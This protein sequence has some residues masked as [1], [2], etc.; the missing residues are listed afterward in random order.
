[1]IRTIEKQLYSDTIAAISTPVGEGAVGIVRLSGDQAFEILERMFKP[2]KNKHLP[3]RMLV[4]GHIVRD[5]HILDEVLAVR[6]KAPKTYTCEDVVEIQCHGGRIAIQEVLAFALSL[7]AR[8]AERGEFTK[9]AFLNGRI[10]LSQAESVMDL[11]GA[12]TKRGYDLAVN[13]LEGAL[14]R[15]IAELRGR[16]IEV[17]ADI[18]V[19]IDYPEEDIEAL[20]YDMLSQKLLEVM[21]HIQVLLQGA[22]KGKIIRDGV[23]TA[24]I[25]KPNVGKSSLMNALLGTSKAIV[26]D[27]AGTTRDVVEEYIHIAGI[28][29]RLMDT[30]GIRETDDT[31][32]RI[33]VERSKEVF[34]AADLILFILDASSPLSQEDREIMMRLE[35][36]SVL[37]VI[38]KTDLPQQL[39]PSEIL[40]AGPI[41]KTSLTKAVGLSDVERA[42]EEMLL[43]GIG[44]QEE[45]EWIT[46]TRHISHLA[47]ALSTLENAHSAALSGMPYDFI[48]VDIKE[49]LDALGTITGET[50]QEDL[51]HSIFSRFCLGK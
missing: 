27:I 34:N 46:N 33:G 40:A 23:R 44:A 9:R 31:V 1:M 43:G 45:S 14:S 4:Y 51:L 30:A 20:T 16:L 49:A 29:I 50:V 12:K 48:E 13:Q 6:M 7:G 35:G 11:I 8:L 24:I 32:E 22:E 36:R 18:A 5:G 41:V 17:L 25:G 39:D 15:Q 42:I 10:D 21:R 2:F 26:T 37:T 3:D 19:C 47:R 38:N 28:P